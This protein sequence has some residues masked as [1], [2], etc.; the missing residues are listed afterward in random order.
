MNRARRVGLIAAVLLLVAASSA[1]WWRF[2]RAVPVGMVV[3]QTGAVAVRVTGPGSV[4]ARV[5]VTLASR[6]T[7]AVTA[8]HADVGDVVRAGQPLVTLDDRD[9]RARRDAVQSQRAA[10]A[11]NVEAA[12]ATLRRAE[13]DLALARSRQQRDAELQASG[14]VST[15]GLDGSRAALDAAVA[16]AEGAAASLAARRAE[17][18]TTEHELAAAEAAQSFTRLDAP[19]DAVVI[20]R[21][22]EPGN[23]VVPGTPVLRLV[24]PATVWIAMRVDEAVL[25]RLRPGQPATVRLRSGQTLNGEVARIARQSDAATREV[26]VHIALAQVPGHFVIDQEA[27]VTVAA[28]EVQ[29]LRVPVDALLRDRQ[30]RLGVL[31]I[32]DGRTRFVAVGAGPSDGEALLVEGELAAGARVVS[33]AAGLRE[34]MRVRAADAG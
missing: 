22:A 9:L 28:G 1:A 3:V 25:G 11:R 17:M 13:A 33:P 4:Q 16:A 10:Q 32:D 15:A 2:G 26:E 6:V 14:F 31:R 23:T 18:A 27:E 20:Q 19:L 29:G 8:V 7:A 30:G 21:L 12:E 34:G 24:D 5:P